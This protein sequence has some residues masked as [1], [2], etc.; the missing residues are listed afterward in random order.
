MSYGSVVILLGPPGSGKGTQ[1]ARLSAELGIPHVSTGDLFRKNITDDTELGRRAQSY[2]QA[3]QLVPDDLVTAMLFE[4]VDEDDCDGGYVLDGYPRTIPQARS[5]EGGIE[6]RLT[7]EAFLLQVPDEV[8]VERAA[9]RMLCRNCDRIHHLKF[10]PPKKPG[11]CDSCGHRAL[12]RRED[13]LPEVV[14]ARLG[15]F[16]AQITPLVDFYRERGRLEVIDGDRPMEEVH[17]L[18]SAR[19]RRAAG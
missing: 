9:G 13:D 14:R 10:D 15:V 8:L 7:S 2:T 4:R 18:L 5:L 6:G 12:Y 11:V 17:S 1:A 19:L 16:R 3:G